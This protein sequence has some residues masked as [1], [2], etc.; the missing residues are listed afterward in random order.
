MF[1]RKSLKLRKFETLQ[2]KDFFNLNFFKNKEIIE[3]NKN[4]DKDTDIILHPEIT[5]KIDENFSFEKRFSK[6]ENEIENKKMKFTLVD[7]FDFI[8][9][10]SNGKRKFIKKINKKF[11]IKLIKKLRHTNFKGKLL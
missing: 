8:K 10:D 6:K 5:I 9:L 4:K 11:Q 3:E 2:K 7:N 1:F